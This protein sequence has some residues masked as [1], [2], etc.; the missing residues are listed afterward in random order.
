MRFL[1]CGAIQTYYNCVRA[2]VLITLKM[3]TRTAETCRWLPRNKI[4]LI[5]PSAFVALFTKC[6][7]VY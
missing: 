4:T 1:K 7:T 3:A 6:Y 5:N 2:L